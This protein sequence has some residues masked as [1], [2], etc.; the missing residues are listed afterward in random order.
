[1]NSAKLIVV[2]GARR[3]KHRNVGDK[4]LFVSVMRYPL[5]ITNINGLK[6]NFA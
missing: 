2:A 4:K 6:E 3:G 1:M 5:L